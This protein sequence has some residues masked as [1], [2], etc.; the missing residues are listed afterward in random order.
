[1]CF[2]QLLVIFWLFYSSFTFKWYDYLKFLKLKKQ[3]VQKSVIKN[4][5]E[6]YKN[7]SEAAKLE[8]KRK[9][10]EKNETDIDSLKKYHEEFLKKQ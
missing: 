4:K 10:L 1:M 7:S 9:H 2:I 6:N 5:F 3:K 8:N